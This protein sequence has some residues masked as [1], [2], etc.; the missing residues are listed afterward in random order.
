M[1]SMLASA[2]SVSIAVRTP[3]GRTLEYETPL[4]AEAADR[5]WVQ[6]SPDLWGRLEPGQRVLVRL[7][8]SE[9]FSL[10][11]TE[12]L[13]LERE[14]VARAALSP[15]A[16]EHVRRIPR[17]QHFRVSAS[18]PVR[19]TFER[20]GARLPEQQVITLSATTFDIS[21]GGLGVLVDRAREVVL[22]AL[23]A[24]GRLEL[25]LAPIDRPAEVGAP[26]VITCDGR[27]ARIEQIEGSSRVLL[28]VHFRNISEQQRV[29]VYRFVIAHQLALRR[30]G[31]LF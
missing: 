20:P 29:E 12:V 7:A 8:H 4:L 1:A 13:V 22:P 3:G 19:F 14:P 26:T 6:I 11:E 18:L 16:P 15:V 23:H 17:R 27:I 31:V 30:R 24:E 10:F 2:E 28:G 25:T 21:S 5:F 9:S